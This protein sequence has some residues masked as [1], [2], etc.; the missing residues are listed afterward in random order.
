MIQ[1]EGWKLDRTN[2]YQEGWLA[3]GNARGLVGVTFTTSHCRTRATELPLRANYNLRGHRSE[4]SLFSLSLSLS[5]I[6]VFTIPFPR[7][8]QACHEASEHHLIFRPLS[9]QA[10]NKRSSFQFVS[11]SWRTTIEFCLNLLKKFLRPHQF[12]YDSGLGIFPD[13]WSA[14]LAD[15][16]RYFGVDRFEKTQPIF[17]QRIHA[18][19]CGMKIE[20]SAYRSLDKE[21]FLFFFLSSPFFLIIYIYIYNCLSGRFNGSE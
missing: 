9:F 3:T 14:K 4:A 17:T 15:Y 13:A 18:V 7:F 19:T 10:V 16:R 5:H 2:Y 1:D 12:C 8:Y 21:F 11:S 20:S 6:C